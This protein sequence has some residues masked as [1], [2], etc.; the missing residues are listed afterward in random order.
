MRIVPLNS[1]IGEARCV[2]S[3]APKGY[4]PNVIHPPQC[5]RIQ[6]SILTPYLRGFL[7]KLPPVSSN[8]GRSTVVKIVIVAGAT[9]AMVAAAT[10]A[11]LPHP[12]PVYQTPQVGKAPIGKAPIGK[13]PV[14]KAPLAT[15]GY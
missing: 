14:G 12:Q 11:D 1:R 3:A 8:L 10:A 2:K 6:G 9:L 5:R 4:C 7:S 15:R 13:S